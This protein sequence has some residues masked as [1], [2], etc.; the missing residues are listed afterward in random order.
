MLRKFGI[1]AITILFASVL[2]VG[3][4]YA[5]G[6]VVD[7]NRESLWISGSGGQVPGSII[8]PDE[9]SITNKAVNVKVISWTND[10]NNFYF[11]IDTY[12]TPPELIDPEFVDVCI[13][14]DN[15]NTTD[16]T[17]AASWAVNQRNRCSYAS[18]VTGIDRVIRAN[19]FGVT[20]YSVTGSAPVVIGSGVL[21]YNPAAPDPVIEV[22]VLVTRVSSLATPCSQA[23][24]AVVYY[25]GSTSDPDDNV[26]DSG[27]FSIQCG[28]PTAVT[29]NSLQAQPTASPV[30][31]LALVGGAAVILIG[32]MLYFRRRQTA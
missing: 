2:V 8:D 7:G 21:G 20:V 31:P 6:I 3:V 25:D 12:G 19:A 29:L 23:L 10:V 5:L 22:G 4:A 32:A 17:S 11:L 9:I 26:P 16:I 27:T 24:E 30:L 15:S 1:V 13:N 14:S 28:A 18:G